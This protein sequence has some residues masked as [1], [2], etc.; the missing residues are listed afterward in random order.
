MG[1]G[2]PA[3]QLVLHNLPTIMSATTPLLP[4]GDT[5]SVF[6]F[7]TALP[8]QISQLPRDNAALA[9]YKTQFNSDL[10]QIQDTI[11][12]MLAHGLTDGHHDKDAKFC[13]DQFRKMSGDLQTPKLINAATKRKETKRIK[14]SEAAAAAQRAVVPEVDFQK[15]HEDALLKIEKLR[16]L[17]K[18][19][20]GRQNNMDRLQITDKPW[21]EC[22]EN[23]REETA[24]RQTRRGRAAV[25]DKYAGKKERYMQDLKLAANTEASL[26]KKIEGFNRVESSTLK[27][28]GTG[29]PLDKKQH[30]QLRTVENCMVKT[31]ELL[32]AATE[33]KK[34]VQRIL[35]EIEE[36]E[37]IDTGGGRKKRMK[38]SAF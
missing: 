32:L 23:K 19:M 21:E 35:D 17:V 13:R 1:C 2:T 12:K 28:E 5:D 20:A 24:K 25:L 30:A 27:Q 29:I 6:L 14:A 33:R 31:R 3:C 37:D 36:A 16:E 4:S 34:E 9:G 15:K 38:L 7:G 10:R 8:F 26:K 22:E 18:K 11:T